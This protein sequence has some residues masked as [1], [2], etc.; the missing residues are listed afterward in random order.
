[1]PLRQR[2]ERSVGI[3]VE[4]DEDQIPNFNAARIIPVHERAARVAV[5]RKIDMQFRARAARTGVAHHPKVVGLTKTGDVDL[6]IEI[7][8]LKQ[9]RP[10]I[11]R[12][13]IKLARL[14]RPRLVNG[15]VKSLRGK[16]PTFDN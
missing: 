7:G 1:M 11:V 2:R 14:A 12:L 4:L 8:I 15:R 6:R 5:R 3:R 13:L 16:F 10:I 9:T